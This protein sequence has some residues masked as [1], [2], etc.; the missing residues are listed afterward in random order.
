MLAMPDN[1]MEVIRTLE[2]RFGWP[3]LVVG[4]LVSKVRGFRAVRANDIDALLAFAN[5]V[6]NVVTIMTLLKSEG[7]MANPTLQTGQS[8]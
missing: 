8:S 6:Q 5:A 1:V 2:R 4:K 7:H 3:E